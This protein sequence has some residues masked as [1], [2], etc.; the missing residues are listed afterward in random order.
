MD[1]KIIHGLIG[2]TITDASMW[3]DGE[4]MSLVLDD[5]GILQITA[6]TGVGDQPFIHYDIE[7][8]PPAGV[9]LEDFDG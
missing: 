6:L 3:E 1:I 9:T 5:G 7:Y 2:R 8:A 4:S